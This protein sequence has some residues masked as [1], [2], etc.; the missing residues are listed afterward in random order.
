M[1]L[2]EVDYL[3]DDGRGYMMSRRMYSV[4]NSDRDAIERVKNIVSEDAFN[5]GANLIDKVF[6]YEVSVKEK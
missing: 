3:L 6:G 1:K 2:Y 4:G 5:F